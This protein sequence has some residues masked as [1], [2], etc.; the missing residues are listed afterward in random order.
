MNNMKQIALACHMYI[1][2]H[3]RFPTDIVDA[4]GKPLLS[5]RVAILPYLEQQ[6]LYNQLHLDEPWDS[7]HNRQVLSSMPMPPGATSPCRMATP[8]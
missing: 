6:G 1:D 4:D 2:S 7:D 5:W 8:Q 3:K